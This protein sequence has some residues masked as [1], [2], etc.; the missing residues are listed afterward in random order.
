M[1]AITVGNQTGA[2][3]GKTGVEKKINGTD[4]P[5]DNKGSNNDSP[6]GA[7]IFTTNYR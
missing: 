7:A 3:E 1:D 5:R 2:V 6:G 4:R